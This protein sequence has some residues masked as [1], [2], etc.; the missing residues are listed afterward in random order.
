MIAALPVRIGETAERR[1]QVDESRVITFMG[2][3]ARIYSTPEMVWDIEETCRDFLVARLPKGF[4]SV[5]SHIGVDHLAP[6]PI[7]MQAVISVRITAIDGR[8][9]SFDVEVRDA[10]ELVGRGRHR[11]VVVEVARTLER[12]RRKA[13]KQ[14]FVRSQRS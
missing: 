9:V 1:I 4:D 6:T 3:E 5:G 2:P 7:G 14:P 8:T 11:R 13:G 12:V 10:Y